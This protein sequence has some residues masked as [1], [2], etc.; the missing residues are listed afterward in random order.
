MKKNVES[1]KLNFTKNLK[2]A[3]LLKIS[4]KSAI[5]LMLLIG[6]NLVLK[7]QVNLISPPYQ[8][9]SGPYIIKIRYR[10]IDPQNSPTAINLT[11]AEKDNRAK[12]AIDH[13]NNVYNKHN[14]YFVWY[15]LNCE[16]QTPDIYTTATIGDIFSFPTFSDAITIY[17][18]VSSGDAEGTTDNIPSNVIHIKGKFGTK[19]AGETNVLIHEMGHCLGLFHT[20]E[21]Q[22]TQQNCPNLCE[23]TGDYVC[24]TPPPPQLNDK[25]FSCDISSPLADN[26]KFNYMSYPRID[27]CRKLF[28]PQQ[29]YRMWSYLSQGHN[30]AVLQECQ[31]TKVVLADE[32]IDNNTAIKI[33]GNVIV[34]T[35]ATLTIDT[36]IK[37]LAGGSITVK[38]GGSLI[39]NSK[40]TSNCPK[41]M[42]QGIIVEGY[43]SFSQDLSNGQQG[44]V[45]I[46]RD[47]TIQ[48]AKVGVAVAKMSINYN[49]KEITYNGGG[50]LRTVG[51]NFIDNEI[52]ISLAPYSFS[53]LPNT[54]RI[55]N[56]YF[57][58]T[59]NFINYSRVQPKFIELEKINQLKILSNCKFIDERDPNAPNSTLVIEDRAN[60]IIAHNA[61]FVVKY[62]TFENLNTAINTNQ[63]TLNGGGFSVENNIFKK[64]F[65]SLFTNENNNFSFY[66]NKIS[67]GKNIV[68]NGEYIGTS[69]NK[70]TLGIFFQL[71]EFIDEN[72]ELS[73][74][75]DITVI[76]TDAIGLEGGSNEIK[77]NTFKNLDIGNRA[78][79]VNQGINDGLF[80]TCNTHDFPQ[81]EGADYLIKKGASI[82]TNQSNAGLPAGN[83][84]ND[85]NERRIN[86]KGTTIEYYYYNNNQENPSAGGGSLG[87][88][89]LKTQTQ[90]APCEVI[91]PCIPCPIIDEQSFRFYSTKTVLNAIKINLQNATDSAQIQ[92]LSRDLFFKRQELNQI[93]N[94]IITSYATDSTQTNIDSLIVWH[95]RMETFE[96]DLILA[97]HYFFNG[98]ISQFNLIWNEIPNKYLLQGNDLIDYNALNNLFTSI[99]NYDPNNFSTELE[100]IIKSFAIQCNDAGVVANIILQSKGIFISPNCNIIEGQKVANSNT[101]SDSLNIATLYPNPASDAVNIKLTHNN[102]GAIINLI[103][104]TGKIIQSQEIKPHIL[105]TSINV[106]SLAKGL[107][108]IEIKTS[109][110]SRNFYKIIIH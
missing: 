19:S 74:I 27:E 52:A 1:V 39:V 13:L 6:N 59:D 71:N 110:Q 79:K 48:Y 100:T 20:H 105:E 55:S 50:V 94:F 60:G 44:F 22:S 18:E 65:L 49:K 84:F 69:L 8:D 43:E 91:Q 70:R 45:S 36:E 101:S 24:D 15:D 53:N 64:C 14:I 29:V 30:I 80:Y 88:I 92:T 87:T 68:E 86:N 72:A 98:N 106:F 28:T 5:I 34:E 41:K 9:Y 103:D 93:G 85:N 96:N 104:I 35:G 90:P 32:T 4:I 108:I 46:K 76:G 31:V 21:K 11:A 99:S 82:R 83:I 25:D 109:Q 107:Y 62:S 102:V 73:S 77:R 12:K 51:A 67:F 61:T 58:I 54:S 66:K 26:Y 97:K 56:T 78:E 75:E 2:L 23:C 42:W 3:H 38:G 89:I 81:A 10:M 17:D 37:M 57:K 16:P 47:A 95:K 40:I 63:Y 33:F 7:A